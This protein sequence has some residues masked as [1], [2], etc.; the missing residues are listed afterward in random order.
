[1]PCIVVG[2]AFDI[3]RDF[4]A[5]NDRDPTQM[6]DGQRECAASVLRAMTT[7]VERSFSLASHESYSQVSLKWIS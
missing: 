3:R 1:M 4:I 7:L 5:Q 6:V 2:A